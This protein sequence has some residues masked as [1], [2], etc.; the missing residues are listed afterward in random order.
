MPWLSADD[1]DPVAA[2]RGR[3]PRC[4]ASCRRR[5]R[6]GSGPPSRCRGPDHVLLEV[7]RRGLHRRLLG[8]LDR[9][10]RRLVD[11]VA[12]L[13]RGQLLLPDGESLGLAGDLLGVDRVG[14]DAGARVRL[15]VARALER[16]LLVAD[17]DL[18]ALA[19]A[20]LLGDRPERLER[21]RLLLDLER[22]GVARGRQRLAAAP[23]RPGRRAGPSGGRSGRRAPPRG[24]AGPRRRRRSSSPK[25][26]SRRRDLRL[27]LAEL[28][29][30][31]G[32]AAQAPVDLDVAQL[33]SAILSPRRSR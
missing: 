20:R 17:L 28:R 4:R 14:L 1:R 30:H 29:L 3:G 27:D 12:A 33:G 13:E 7:A 23:C 32:A 22:G 19:R 18:E 31:L 9:P 24:P 15:V 25:V 6:A 10:Q 21:A 5:A 26:P 8:A 2:S 16:R 11:A